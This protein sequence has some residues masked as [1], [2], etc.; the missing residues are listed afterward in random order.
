MEPDVY[1]SR[2]SKQG[3]SPCLKTLLDKCEDHFSKFSDGEIVGIKMTIGDQHSTANI[4]PELVR[5]LVDRLK[6][7]GVKPFVFDT[8]V[9]YKGQRQNSV[10]HLNLAYRKGFTPE[11]LGC[12]YIIADSVF[13]TD[14]Q[15]LKVD[16]KNLKEIKIPSLIKV[17]D[18]LIVLSHITGHIMSGYAA[19]LKNV[20]MGMASRAGKQIQ[21]SSLKPTINIANCTLC[22]GCIESCPASAISENSGKAFINTNLCIGCGE[23]IASCKSDGININWREE[24]NVFAEK[25]AEYACGI[26]SRIKNRVFMNFAIDIT[27]E[28][29]CIAGDDPRFIKDTGIFLSDDI[30]AV[31]KACFDV[32]TNK[33]DY[34]SRSGK[35][36]AH[37]HEF[38]YAEEIGLGSLAYN[39]IKI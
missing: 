2:I 21:H 26:L 30:L 18:N 12:P 1:F 25:K 35:I 23:C 5:M 8:N 34:F 31:D 13:G 17:M 24:S 3:H 7:R 28:C 29:D 15:S 6:S 22:G 20:A 32:L 33:T 4:K 19:S 16:F 10:D 14:S 9:I 37:L 27:E 11:N 36:K 38:K 39:L